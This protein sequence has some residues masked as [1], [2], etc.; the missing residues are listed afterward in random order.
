MVLEGPQRTDFQLQ[1]VVAEE[2]PA[3]RHSLEVAGRRSRREDS[4]SILESASW[5][6]VG[7]EERGV[8]PDHF[9]A[10]S[11]RGM[12]IAMAEANLPPHT[13]VHVPA[14]SRSEQKETEERP[15][16]MA[17]AKGEGS[18]NKQARGWQLLQRRWNV[19]LCCLSACGTMSS[20]CDLTLTTSVLPVR[21]SIN[22]TGSIRG[23]RSV[24]VPVR[25]YV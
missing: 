5:V 14:V 25:P 17:F 20:K 9:F 16:R 7:A 4:C 15:D 10:A 3:L 23:R 18:N 24:R 13:R 12:E 22:R 2:V 21:S 11:V 1:G 19:N 8:P 6:R